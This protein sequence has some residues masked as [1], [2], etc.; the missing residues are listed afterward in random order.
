MDFYVSRTQGET[1]QSEKVEVFD[2]NLSARIPTVRYDTHLFLRKLFQWGFEDIIVSP[3]GGVAES[4]YLKPVTELVKD[5]GREGVYSGTRGNA[6][7]SKATD[8]D[9]ERFWLL[10]DRA[11]QDELAK[12]GWMIFPAPRKTS[13][14]ETDRQGLSGSPLR[15]EF[16]L[17]DLIRAIKLTD[18]HDKKY[19]SNVVDDLSELTPFGEKIEFFYLGD[20]SF[21]SL[22]V[23]YK[24]RHFDLKLTPLKQLEF[25]HEG[26]TL[27]RTARFSLPFRGLFN[28]DMSWWTKEHKLRVSRL[29][30]DYTER[31]QLGNSRG[32]VYS[33]D[34]GLSV[35][36]SSRP[37]NEVVSS[38]NTQDLLDRSVNAYDFVERIINLEHESHQKELD[39]ILE[40]RR[41]ELGLKADTP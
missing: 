17:T 37:Y 13:D 15:R 33:A 12:S 22:G 28:G 21:L 30:N 11:F 35:E 38:P 39:R 31:T 19:Y 29:A 16:S 23:N 8:E 14:H 2:F 6:D 5:T 40:S 32:R 27:M 20:D 18:F 7:Y 9:T 26:N 24:D 34:M 3:N 25:P 4:E 1:S 41:S 10:R 36:L